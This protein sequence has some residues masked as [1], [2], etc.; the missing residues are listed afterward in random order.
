MMLDK[1]KEEVLEISSNLNLV[2]NIFPDLNT[3]DIKKH[4]YASLALKA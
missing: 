4:E 2:I 1:I 3:S